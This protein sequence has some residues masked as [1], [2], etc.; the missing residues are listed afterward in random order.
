MRFPASIRSVGA[1]GADD[2][3]PGQVY[4]RAVRQVVGVDPAAFCRLLG[5]PVPT[6]SPAA[7]AARYPQPTLEA[8]LVLRTGPGELLH[9]EYQR[10]AGPGLARRM[11]AYRAAIM[12]AYPGEELEQ[13]VL[14]LGDGR[15]D[16]VDDPREG[17]FRLGCRVVHLRDVDPEDLLA[18]PATAPLAVLGRGGPEVRARAFLRALRLVAGEAG[19]H[20]KVLVEAASVLA[21]IRLDRPMIEKIRE[22]AGMTVESVADFWAETE[23]GRVLQQRAREEGLERGRLQALAALLR[24]RFGD[25]PDVEEAAGRLAPAPDFDTVVRDV[26]TAGSLDELLAR[27]PS[28]GR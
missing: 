22:E 20:A 19:A 18:R 2:D 15:M 27:Y 1:T 6:A 11:L 9:V 28:D 12:T 26:S 7:L 14:V 13:V 8:D 3:R 24:V 5:V 25:G 10:R 21:T 23:F 17:G 16:S 4:D